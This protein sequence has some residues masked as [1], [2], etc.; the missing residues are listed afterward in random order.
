MSWPQGDQDRRMQGVI[1]IGTVTA[2]DAAAAR[3]KVSLGGDSETASLPWSVP[4]AGGVKVWVP[5]SVGE[6]VI[7]ASPGGDT[8]Q[9]V[10]IGRMFSGSN[11][12]PS[13]DGAEHLIE[14]GDAWISVKGGMIEISAGGTT[15]SIGAGGVTVNADVLAEGVSLIGHTHTGDSGGTTSPPS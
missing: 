7:I 12:A 4:A 9:G 2:V 11:A 1:R 6:Q 14:V 8:A 10:I 13:G 5:V 15:I 3:A